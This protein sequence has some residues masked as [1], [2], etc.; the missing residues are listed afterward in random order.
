MG[1][2][3]LVG[4]LVGSALGVQVFNVLQDLGQ[5]DL[6]V[7]LCYVVFLGIVGAMMLVESL[8]ALPKVPPRRPRPCARRHNWVHALPLKV[9]FRVS[10]PLYLRSSRRS[11]S[12]PSSAFSRRSWGWAAASSWS[13]P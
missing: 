12:A 13:P 2:V 9:K 11:P 8:N 5:I 4:G 1:F 7:R 3:L 6:A 10:G